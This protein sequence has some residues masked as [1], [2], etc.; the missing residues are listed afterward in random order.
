MSAL[1]F[2]ENVYVDNLY[3]KSC[4]E[5]GMVGD[6]M[7]ELGQVKVDEKTALGLKVNLPDSPPLV[8]IVGEKGFV[9]CGFLNIDVAEKLDVTAA[10]V[11]EVETFDDV[12]EAK[13]KAATSKAE[14]KGIKPGIKGRDAVKLLF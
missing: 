2:T 4:L 1:C 3:L 11:S 6:G 13:V 8:V 10:M 7:I 5:E 12:L 14:M 9:M